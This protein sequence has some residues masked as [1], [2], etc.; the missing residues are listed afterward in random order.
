MI[1]ALSIGP[2]LQHYAWVARHLRQLVITIQTLR[3]PTASLAPLRTLFQRRHT[4]N[5]NIKTCTLG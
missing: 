3:D 2:R 1:V 5:R 4:R